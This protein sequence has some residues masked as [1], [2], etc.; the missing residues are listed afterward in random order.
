L[1][2]TASR[3]GSFGR[4]CATSSRTR[5][6]QC[7][8][9]RRWQLRSRWEVDLR[10]GAGRLQLIDEALSTSGAGAQ[11]F[12]AGGRRYGTSWTAHGAPPRARRLLLRYSA[13]AAVAEALS[14]AVFVMSTDEI[15]ARYQRNRD[16]CI[17]LCGLDGTDLLPG[18]VGRP[19]AGRGG[20]PVNLTLTA[21]QQ[22]VLVL[23]RFSIGWHFF[24]Q[25]LGKLQAAR[26]SSESTCARAQARRGAVPQDGRL[27]HVAQG[28]RSRHD[29]GPAHPRLLMMVGLFTRTATVLSWG[30]CCFFTCQP[31]LPVHGFSVRTPD[32]TELYINKVM[33]EMMACW[34]ASPL[35][36]AGYRSRHAG[37][38]VV[39][40]TPEREARRPGSSRPTLEIAGEFSDDGTG[41]TGRSQEFHKGC[42]YASARRPDLE[43][44][45]AQPRPGCHHRPRR[46]GARTD[47]AH[48][49]THMKYV[50]VCDIFPP[51][52]QKGLDIA[53]KLHD[54]MSRG[55]AITVASWNVKTSMP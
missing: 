29:V 54:R 14:T 18:R 32:G 25:G 30:C 40:S 50:A 28:G 5:P 10:G 47:G 46:A 33:I 36:R 16:T 26:W 13:A 11:F 15:R 44:G 31:P 1:R 9:T 22:F 23:L 42:G 24:Y 3:T 19:P 48:Q 12:E 20:A 7:R 55:T 45:V 21:W 4:A 2:W 53:R 34:S 49:P 43:G 41:K 39:A 51:N 8:G 37:R 6:Q 35:T 17:I 38:P 52:L 27:R